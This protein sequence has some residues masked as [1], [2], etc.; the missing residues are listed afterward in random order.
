M[1]INILL[2]YM[3]IEKRG[4]CSLCYESYD[5]HVLHSRYMSSTYPS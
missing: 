3:M 5:E 2:Q 4:A 1:S